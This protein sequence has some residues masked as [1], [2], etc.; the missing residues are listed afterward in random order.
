MLSKIIH[1]I[2]NIDET[3]G[4]IFLKYA[5]SEN[6]IIGYAG[7]DQQVLNSHA[8]FLMTVLQQL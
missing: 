6:P 8:S 5:Y 7:Y 2:I 3:L 1:T 4:Y